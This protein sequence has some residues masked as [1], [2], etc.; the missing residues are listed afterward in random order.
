[1]SI[2]RCAQLN[3]THKHID[4]GRND[5][6]DTTADRYKQKQIWLGLRKLQIFLGESWKSC[7]VVSAL[8]VF[9]SLRVLWS[10]WVFLCFFFR[11]FLIHLYRKRRAIFTVW[12]IYFE[13]FDGGKR[14]RKKLKLANIFGN[15][16]NLLFY[17]QNSIV[18]LSFGDSCYSNTWNGLSRFKPP[19]YPCLLLIIMVCGD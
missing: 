14:E 17:C 19:I 15:F 4:E 1:M 16:F 12:F 9:L 11:R 8:F 18:S 10:L 5:T 7:S 6:N 3:H 2:K 13:L